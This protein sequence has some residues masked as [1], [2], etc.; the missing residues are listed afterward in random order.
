MDAAGNFV[1]AYERQGTS[2]QDTDVIVQRYSNTGSFQGSVDVQSSSSFNELRPSVA[3]AAD[4]R[5]AVAY[6]WN[7]F[8][9]TDSHIWTTTHFANG[10]RHRGFGIAGTAADE[11][12]PDIAMNNFGD[13]VVAY[14]EVVGGDRDIKAQRATFDGPVGGEIHINGS[15]DDE[16]DPQVAMNRTGRSFVVAFDVRTSSGAFGVD[17]VEISS[18]DARTDLPAIQGAFNAGVSMGPNGKYLVTYQRKVGTDENIFRRRGS[19]STL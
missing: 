1:V 9:S 14:T 13:L 15:V 18:T 3:M 4:G 17:L 11:G 6:E 2:S 5:F 10:T 16:F 7:D 19:F 12:N 8:G